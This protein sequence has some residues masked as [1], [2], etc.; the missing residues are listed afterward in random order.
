MM[1]KRREKRDH[2]HHMM[3]NMDFRSVSAT[4]ANIM[5]QFI[6]TLIHEGPQ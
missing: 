6:V 5:F 1:E 3:K 4:F 2:I